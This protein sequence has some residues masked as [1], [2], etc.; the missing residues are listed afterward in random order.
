MASLVADIC[1]AEPAPRV[2][3]LLR[4][5]PMPIGPDVLLPARETYLGRRIGRLEQ[6]G[7]R[8]RDRR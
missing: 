3:A 6:R 1:V 5:E 4:S 7:D 2:E 8:L